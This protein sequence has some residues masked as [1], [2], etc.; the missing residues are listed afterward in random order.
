MFEKPLLNQIF[1]YFYY[2][3]MNS[4]VN[5]VKASEVSFIFHKIMR[6]SLNKHLGR[7]RKED[8][9]TATGLIKTFIQFIIVNKISLSCIKSL[10]FD[11]F[12]IL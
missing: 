9:L 10:K 6:F 11:Y 1:V 3:V 2:S 12:Y 4:G 5:F 8:I 7:W